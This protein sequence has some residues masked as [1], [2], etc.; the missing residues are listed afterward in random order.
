VQLERQVR[1]V[2]LEAMELRVP[3]VL[4]VRRVHRVMLDRLGPRVLSA[5]LVM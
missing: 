3:L 4:Q 2:L 1:K 5:Q